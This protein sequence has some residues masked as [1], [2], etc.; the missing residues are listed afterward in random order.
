MWPSRAHILK[1][2]T[3][4]A[5][6]KKGQ[7]LHWSDD[8]QA[9][10]DKMK[11]LCAADALAAY[12]DHNKRFDIYTDANDYQLGAVICQ[13]GRPVAYFTR[14]LSKLQRNYIT[15]EKEMFSIVLTLEEFCDMLLGADIHIWTDHKNL[16]FNK[17]SKTQRV[18][19]WGIKVEEFSPFLHHIDGEKNILADQLSH[20]EIIPTPAQLAEGKKLVE[21]TEVTVTDDEGDENDEAYFLDQEFSGL[22]DNDIWDCVECYLNLPEL[23]HPENNPLSYAYI[24]EISS[25]KMKLCWLYS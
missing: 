18:L 24:R 13:E 23:E 14:K 22:Y 16:C 5:G 8:M 12:P 20:L 6:L 21:P 7:S 10:F 19:R 9:A 3:D 11:L 2:L 25:K 15:M 1:P 17:D 4:K